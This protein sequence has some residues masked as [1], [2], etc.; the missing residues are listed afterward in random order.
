MCQIEIVVCYLFA[1]QLPVG[2]HVS[3][4]V[5]GDAENEMSA[6]IVNSLLIR[7][8]RGLVCAVDRTVRR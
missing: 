1:F 2:S 6:R 5:Q 8:Q 4:P 7:M 3:W